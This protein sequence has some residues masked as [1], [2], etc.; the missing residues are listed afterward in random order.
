MSPAIEYIALAI[1]RAKLSP[2][3]KSKRGVVIFNGDNFIAHGYNCPPGRF[4]CLDNDN[5]RANCRRVSVHA[6]ERAIIRA[7]RECNGADLIHIKV[8]DGKPVASGAPSCVGCSRLI[9]AA[10]IREVWLYQEQGWRAWTAEDFHIAT[11]ESCGL[12]IG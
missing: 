9:Y 1:E 8:V 11:L 2:C 10:G 5:C 7:G 6:E 3:V 4:N 12:P